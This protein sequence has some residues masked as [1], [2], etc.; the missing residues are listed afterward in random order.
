ML[1]QKWP[2]PGLILI[3]GGFLL[4]AMDL[5][6]AFSAGSIFGAV[7]GG[8]GLWVWW[9][10]YYF[11]AFVFNILNV[12]MVL[13]FLYYVIILFQGWGFWLC[14]SGAL[15]TVWNVLYFNSPQTKKLF[16]R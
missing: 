11:R 13:R 8:L 14:L 10:I 1:K 9:N 16:H 7:F 15:Y 6:N 12:M 2:T 4:A 3:C 5:M